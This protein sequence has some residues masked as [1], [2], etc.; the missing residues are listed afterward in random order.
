MLDKRIEN[1]KNFFF[2]WFVKHFHFLVLSLDS[3]SDLKV[4]TLILFTT[5]QG[6]N[7]CIHTNELKNTV[8]TFIID[9]TI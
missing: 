6:I 2:F 1:L 5:K 8:I 9:F 4:A 3:S 7:A